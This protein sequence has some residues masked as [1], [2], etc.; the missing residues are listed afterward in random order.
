MLRLTLLALVALQAVP[1]AAK[2]ADDATAVC[3][4]EETNDPALKVCPAYITY[5]EEGEEVGGSSGL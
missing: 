2:T 3:G 4:L 1:A 5:D